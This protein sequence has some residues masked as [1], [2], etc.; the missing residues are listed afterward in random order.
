MTVW[1]AD[2]PGTLDRVLLVFSRRRIKPACLHAEADRS[3]GV[4]CLTLRF[5]SASGTDAMR[6]AH[7]VGRGENVYGL[8]LDPLDRTDE[9][10]ER[11]LAL[12]RIRCPEADRAALRELVRGIALEEAAAT[13]EHVVVALSGS[14]AAVAD[15]LQA[16]SALNVDA[17][18]RTHVHLLPESCVPVAAGLPPLPVSPHY[19]HCEEDVTWHTCTMTTTRMH[20]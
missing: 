3:H 20:P 4:V 11:E 9:G 18:Q 6:V 15:A 13:P 17:V 19:S 10:V 16:L 12:V 5:D 14:P 8:A 1:M 2:E 7:Q